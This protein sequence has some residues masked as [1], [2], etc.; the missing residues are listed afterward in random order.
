MRV[1]KVHKMYLSRIIRLF[2]IRENLFFFF[3]FAK[4]CDKI[5]EHFSLSN[6]GLIRSN[7][8][9]AHSFCGIL[10]HST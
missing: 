8:E 6:F 5:S 7:L 10:A 3:I 1:L 4:I 9:A 2:K